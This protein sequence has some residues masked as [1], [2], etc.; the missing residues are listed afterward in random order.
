ML[1]GTKDERNFH[2]VS[3]AAIAQIVQEPD[4]EERWMKAKNKEALRDI[5]LLGQRKRLQTDR[6]IIN[7]K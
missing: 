6:G 5:V 2:L 1:L 4:F 3:L 7:L